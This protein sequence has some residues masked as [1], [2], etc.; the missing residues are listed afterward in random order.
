LHFPRIRC[1]IPAALIVP[2]NLQGY[3]MLRLIADQ[4]QR[5]EL[6][7]RSR[8]A[9]AQHHSRCAE[10]MQQPPRV[11]PRALEALRIRRNTW[12]S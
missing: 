4:L 12:K 10:S 8:L 2:S 1:R 3:D 9:R 6:T 5:R 7:Y 11:A